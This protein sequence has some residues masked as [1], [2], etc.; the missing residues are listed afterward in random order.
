MMRGF[1]FRF[2]IDMMGEFSAAMGDVTSGGGAGGDDGFNGL[3]R[4]LNGDC[5]TEIVPSNG[6][7]IEGN[8]HSTEHLAERLDVGLDLEVGSRDV[9]FG[10]V[11]VIEFHLC[12]ERP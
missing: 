11:G 4:G 10:K 12:F 6:N 2:R 7:V 9:D 5:A 3:V 1:I 8:A